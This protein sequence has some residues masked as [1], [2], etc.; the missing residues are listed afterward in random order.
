MRSKRLYPG[1]LLRASLTGSG[2]VSNGTFSFTRT[3]Q[4]D[5][6]IEGSESILIKLYSDSGRTRQVGSTATVTVNDTST[7]ESAF[8][9]GFLGDDRP[10]ILRGGTGIDT[11]TGL[12]NADTLTGGAGADTFRYLDLK[13]SVLAAF[14]RITDFV[15]GLDLIDAPFPVAAENIKHLGTVSTFTQQGIGAVLTSRNFQASRAATFTAQI[16]GTTRSFLAI[17]DSNSGFDPTQDAIIEITGY[18]GRLTH[19]SII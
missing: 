7:P 13:D 15:T 8:R 11:I 4:N 6:I 10:N 1:L 16:G 17:N 12:G 14:D 5:Q 3:L 19:I 18:T 9:D 2:V